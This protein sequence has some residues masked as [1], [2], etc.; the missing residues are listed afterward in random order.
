[1]ATPIHKLDGIEYIA[2]RTF[3]LHGDQY[4]SGDPV[5]NKALENTHV[6]ALIRSRHVIPVVDDPD[7]LPKIYWREV[8]VRSAALAKL[9]K[10]DK[11]EAKQ[12]DKPAAKKTATKKTAK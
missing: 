6:E 11:R 9:G 7:V 12:A 10:E 8:K 5:P 2:G 3:T 4:E 1:M